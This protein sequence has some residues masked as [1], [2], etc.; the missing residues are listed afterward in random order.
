MNNSLPDRRFISRFLLVVGLAAALVLFFIYDL[1]QYLNLDFLRESRGV[2]QEIYTR[3]PLLMMCAF[4]L[5]YVVTT[6][7]S[8]PGATVLSQEGRCSAGLEAP[9]SC[10]SQVPSE[11]NWPC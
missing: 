2:F 10:L 7:L 4:F 8:L 11:P 6:A 1:Q 9:L 3:Q 5:V